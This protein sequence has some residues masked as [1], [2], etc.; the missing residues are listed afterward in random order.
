MVRMWLWQVFVNGANLPFLIYFIILFCANL[1][2]VLTMQQA[3]SSISFTHCAVFV[4]I[5]SDLQLCPRVQLQ[6]IIMYLS[7][8]SLS[9][10]VFAFKFCVQ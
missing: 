4:V 8:Y 7:L 6:A 5:E 2:N 3:L 9:V 1:L 10:S